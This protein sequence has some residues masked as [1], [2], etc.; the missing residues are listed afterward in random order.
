[1][2]RARNKLAFH[3]YRLWLGLMEG[4]LICLK[5]V[6]VQNYEFCVF[7]GLNGTDFVCQPQL[8]RTAAA[9]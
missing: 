3:H 9:R 1:M 2:Q 8:V 6:V 4:V 5:S 7:A